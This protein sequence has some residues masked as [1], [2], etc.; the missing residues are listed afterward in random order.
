MLRTIDSTIPSNDEIKS[1]TKEEIKSKLPLPFQILPNSCQTI[2]QTALNEIQTII[3]NI[4]EIGIDVDADVDTAVSNASL[5]LS[6]LEEDALDDGFILCDLNVVQRK[7]VAW[8]KMFPRVKPFFALKCNPDVMVAHVLGLNPDCGFDCASISEIRLALSSSNGDSRRC[9]YANPQ[10][11]RDDLD[12]SLK[13]GTGALTFDGS[14]ELH[15]VKDA[16][17]R[18]LKQQQQQRIESATATATALGEDD[19]DSSLSL[20]NNMAL[21]PQMILRILVP[22]DQSTVP[23]G[24]KFG[25]PPDRVQALTEEALELG[26]DVIGVSFHCGSGC[27]D[28]EAFGNAIKIAKVAI[29][30]INIVIARRNELDGKDRQECRLLDIGGGYPG[31][32]AIGADTHR[33]SSTTCTITSTG[34]AHAINDDYEQQD[35]VSTA[36][37]VSTVV[38]PLIDNLFPADK[39]PIQVISEP[40]RYFVEAAFIYCAR[41][42]SVKAEQDEDKKR[43]YYISQGVHGLFKDVLLCDE[44][45][46]PI[47]L[48]INYDEGDAGAG[49][50]VGAGAGAGASLDTTRP[51]EA[52]FDSI[53]HGPSGEDFDVVCKACK[54]PKLTIGDWLI[55]DRMGAYTLSIAARNSSLPVR[56]VFGGG[57]I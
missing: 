12:A 29:D 24:E 38:T 4:N 1:F 2:P 3:K 10:R 7:L 11:A 5:S 20:S 47:P 32:D 54:L 48:M 35:N 23:L 56:Y 40:G 57:G 26:F 49:V 33:F 28:A 30:D 45:F 34:T 41:I 36:Y 22:D 15:K 14:E 39:S 25:A 37:Q 43:H 46:T 6:S 55:F 17:E 8:Y 44:S 52:V 53:V 42:Y 18:L 13:L 16:H 51:N 31:V 9:V 50:G 27:H 21:P 19:S